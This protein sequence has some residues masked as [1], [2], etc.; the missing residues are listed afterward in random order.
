MNMKKNFY[1]RK[2]PFVTLHDGNFM[3][4]RRAV[5][6][7]EKFFFQ[8]DSPV[9]R[10]QLTHEEKVYAVAVSIVSSPAGNNIWKMISCHMPDEIYRA[11]SCRNSPLSQQFLIEK[12]SQ[13][14]LEAAR[15]IVEK[16]ARK[17]ID[18]LTYWDR[19]YPALLREIQWPPIVLYVK[20]VLH[21]ERA[22]A[23]V[24]TRKSDGR[25][26][27][28]ARRI[29]RE[30]AGRGYTVVS[31]MAVGIDRE[32]HLG[33]LDEKGTTIGVLAN[34]IDITYPWPN[35]DL[36]RLIEASPGSALISEYPPG[37]FAGKWT[38]VRRNRIISGLCSGTVVIKAG[39]RS[40]ALI[41]ARHAVEQNREVFACTGNSFDDEYAGCHHLIRSGAVLV[42]CS[43]DIIAELSRIMNIRKTGP[44][45]DVE[46]HDGDRRMVRTA[47]ETSVDTLEGRIL[48]LL[49]VQDYDIDS[50]VRNV[51]GNPGEVNEAVVAMELDGRIIR[52]GNIISRL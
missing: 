14:P 47:D 37:I 45:M 21:A 11:I 29:S 27:A 32:A 12:Y 30:L 23:V 28:H 43:D 31:G 18:V 19:D 1:S 33:A 3:Y 26:S 22:V 17:S 25:S 52:N 4:R 16:A 9:L 8:N 5:V 6:M 38:F 7:Q 42:S 15:M 41:T 39:N 20:G 50:I 10:D 35:R 46:C 24:G 2:A 40:G 49:S 51:N 36:Y 44:V 34:G 13:H 48:R